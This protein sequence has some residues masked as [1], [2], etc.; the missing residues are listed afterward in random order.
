MESNREEPVDNN[1]PLPTQEA[2]LS[3]STKGNGKVRKSNY[4]R[5]ELLSLFEVMER[6]Q[7]IGTEEWEQV[8]M[9]H[10]R[11]YPGRDIESIRRKY[12]TLHRKQVQTGIIHSIANKC[13]Q[14]TQAFHPK[15]LP[16]NE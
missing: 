5:D 16:Q 8:L 10:S 9:E 14:A 7:P 1:L 11:N 3:K 4:S 6:I 13:R 12:N 15:F 2:T